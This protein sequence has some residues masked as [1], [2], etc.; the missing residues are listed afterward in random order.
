M[1]SESNEEKDLNSSQRLLLVLLSI[2]LV[3]TL[4]FFK[5][6][7]NLNSTLDQL[8]RNSPLP[9]EALSN[10]RPTM[11]EFYADWCEACKEM[12]PS[13]IS[14]K[15]RHENKLNVV[16]L[17]VDN[18][19]WSDLIEKYD[20]NGIPQLN[21][22]DENGDFRGFSLGV[23]NEIELN[24]IFYALIN[25]TEL[26]SLSKISTSSDLNIVSY[27][28]DQITMNNP[29]TSGPRSHN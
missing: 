16:L 23:K 29:K 13:M 10:G 19:Q 3:L 2:C 7:L 24:D 6:G 9:E 22:F 18:P 8:A 26:P 27:S 25:D 4:F 1:T 17:D 21:F 15:K 20:V 12:A 14:V 28:K 5:N 11:I